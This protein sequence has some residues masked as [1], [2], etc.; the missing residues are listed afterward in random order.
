[1]AMPCKAAAYLMS[2]ANGRSLQPWPTEQIDETHVVMLE[3]KRNGVKK[4]AEVG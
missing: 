4:E 3:L 2:T 1:M